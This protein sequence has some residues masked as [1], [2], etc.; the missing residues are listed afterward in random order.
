MSKY[1][2]V[3]LCFS[4][5]FIQF[6]SVPAFATVY[7]SSPANNGTV[8][9]SVNFAA[10]ASTSCSKGIASMGIYPAPYQLAFVG[11]GSSLNHTLSLSTGKYNAVIVAW[12]NCGGASSASVAITVSTSGGG[13]SFTNLQRS[14]GWKGYGQGPPNYVDCSPCSKVSWSMAQ[15]VKSP[16]I[17]GDSSQYNIWGSGPYWDV[18]FNNHLIGDG[19]SQGMLDSNHTIVPNL[20]NFTYDVYFF[21]NNLGAS[22]ALEFD[23][24]QFFSGMGF[25]WGTECKIAGGHVWDV[26]DNIGQRWVST[27]IPCNPNNNAWN[28]LTLKVQR[29]SGNKLLYQSIT[30]NGV[31]HN[32]NWTYSPGSAPGWYGITVNYQMD[33]N[34][35]QAPYSIYLDEL[36]FSYQ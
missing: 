18:L 5:A 10:K 28:H 4:F 29:T 30:L 17:S 32:L 33:G 19:S 1:L 16:S 27:G 25:I 22:Q 8:G 12:D 6:L 26:W 21:G 23:V 3:F 13:K 31:T 14:G 9:G 35:V 36:T 20:H 15:G 11:S 2:L 7:I 24:N 34:G